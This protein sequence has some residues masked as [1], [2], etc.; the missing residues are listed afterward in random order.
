MLNYSQG[1]T[2]PK[3]NIIDSSPFGNK[4]NDYRTINTDPS[5]ITPKND[6]IDETP[7]NTDVPLRNETVPKKLDDDF[8]RTT[9][10]L[11]IKPHNAQ[12][13]RAHV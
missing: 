8:S 4:N 6:A 3:G 10:P 9:S 13:G 7:I 12:I 2:S 11:D 1:I 5:A